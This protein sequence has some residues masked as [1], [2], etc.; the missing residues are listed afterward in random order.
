MEL[1]LLIKNTSYLVTTKIVKFLIGIVRAKLTAV[2]LGTTG[3]GIIAQLTSVVQQMSSFT[4][5]SVN[6][7]LVKQIAENKDKEDFKNK[8]AYLLKSYIAI[9]TGLTLI[10]LVLLFVFSEEITVYVLGN[11]KYHDYFIIGLISFPI[12][13]VNSISFALLKGHKEIKYIARSELLVIV[14]DF[15]L[16]V[17]LIY[18]WGITGAVVFVPLSLLTILIVNNYYARTKVLKRYAV[19]T[20]D[21]FSAVISTR[22]VKELFVF[23]GVGLTAGIALIVSEIACRAVVVKELGIDKIG[24]YGPLIAWANLFTGFIMPSLRTYLY[25]RFSET[26]SDAEV[27]GILNDVLRLVS[28]LMIPALFLSIPIRYK[29]IPIFYSNDFI[30]A[31]DYLPWHFLGNLFYF[32]MYA[33]RTPLS[34]TGRIKTHGIIVIVM[35]LLDFGVVYFFVPLLGLYGWMLKFIISPILF[36]ALILVYLRKLMDF[37]IETRNKYIMLYVLVGALLIIGIDEFIIS[38]YK[39]N[40]LIGMLLTGLSFWLLSATERKIIINKFRSMM[41]S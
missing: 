28:F 18:F 10:C 23:A 41:T 27:S 33:L 2:F 6:D 26:K 37:K 31:G 5:M 4:L 25:P 22:A 21:V 36:F 16:F 35:S 29:I 13:I 34:P 8:L 12:L 3:T 38:D 11:I 17:P 9:I 24:I 40:L 1:K 19:Y 15:I 39:F 14:I 20:R 30:S 7:G 32:W